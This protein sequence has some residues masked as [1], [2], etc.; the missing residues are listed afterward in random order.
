MD[1]CD[2]LDNTTL[3]YG[4]GL[5]FTNNATGLV[6][7]CRVIGNAAA[8]GLQRGRRHLLQ[9]VADHLPQPGHRRQPRLGRL[10]RGRRRGRELRAL[11]HLRELH[12]RRQHAA[13]AASPPAACTRPSSRRPQFT[14]C[15]IAN[16]TAG[17][18]I[19]CV[20]D[21][22]PV[23]TGCDVWG[24]AGGNALCGVDGGC[25]FS[26]NPLFCTEPGL[27]RT[28]SRPAAPARRATI[29]RAVAAPPT[30]APTPPAAPIVAR[31]GRARGRPARARQHAQSV[32]P[33]DH[34]PLPA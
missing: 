28:A 1:D 5:V 12:H 32:Q 13:A 20:F 8:V 26:A 18:G 25:N 19:S 15:I 10:R 7:N 2:I 21:A 34:D 6:S 14:N 27:R 9:P 31:R 3:G 30:A 29:P 24:N 22:A 17:L 16:S 23:F 11:A 33:A 4:G